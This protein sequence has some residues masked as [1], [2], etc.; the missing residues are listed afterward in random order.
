VLLLLPPTRKRVAM[1]EAAI[2]VK[3][4]TSY[5]HEALM[6]RGRDAFLAGTVGFLREGLANGQPVMAMLASPRLDD[7]R[8]ALGD[9]ADRVTL[10]DM[11]EVG[12]NP[13][14]I[15][16]TWREFLDAHEPD[17]PVRGVGEPVWSGRRGIEIAE[18]QLHEALLNLAVEPDRP[19]WLRCPYDVDALDPQIVDAAHRSHPVILEAENY[20]GSTF[21][22][23]VCHAEEMFGER[24]PDPPVSSSIYPFDQANAGAVVDYATN[25]AV[26]QGLDVSR[27]SGLGTA[28]GE[29]VDNS[30]RHGGGRG[31]LHVWR[32]GEAFVCEVRDTGHIGDP[33]T[34]RH[35]PNGHEARPASGLWL[36][37][38]LCDLVQLRSSADGTTVRLISWLYV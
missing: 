12:A 9:D 7:V 20:R 36:A 11:A 15:L 37:N 30:V 26:E 5:Q 17:V 4:H 23:G 27:V 2:L 24:L 35:H 19:F 28:L 14:R 32:D 10:R 34:G 31:T 18:C 3:P 6:Y 29:V 33:L 1:T 25:A 8:E 13:A 22:G 16:P 38:Q 21:Y